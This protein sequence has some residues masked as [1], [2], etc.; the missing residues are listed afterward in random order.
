MSRL[1]PLKAYNG[2]TMG[3]E[4]TGPSYDEKAND[5]DD[6]FMFGKMILGQYCTHDKDESK[7]GIYV[8]T[9]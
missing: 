5:Y 8:I 1:C 4:E 6:S 3:N 9:I 2:K 7:N